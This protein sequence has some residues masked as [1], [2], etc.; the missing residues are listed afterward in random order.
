MSRFRPPSPLF[1]YSD[2]DMQAELA[3]HHQHQQ[4]PSNMN[5]NHYLN[6]SI[7]YSS[8]PS[9]YHLLSDPNATTNGNTIGA[10]STDIIDVHGSDSAS[11]SSCSV[12]SSAASSFV[13]LPLAN[14]GVD[15][16]STRKESF[17]GGYDNVSLLF[18]FFA[19]DVNICI[20]HIITV[21]LGSSK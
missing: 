11:V 13:H 17:G 8:N 6:V 21:F 14:T 3:R 1:C 7:P 16:I 9:N 15:D 10:Q 4:Q 19:S 18:L 20:A 12:P 5:S 2:K